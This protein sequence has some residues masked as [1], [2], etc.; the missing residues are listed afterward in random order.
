MWE[1]KTD[2]ISEWNNNNKNF[3]RGRT[4]S[5]IAVNSIPTKLKKKKE[6]TCSRYVRVRTAEA[7]DKFKSDLLK[8]EWRGV[9][10]EDVNAA[11]ES[12]LQI[13]ISLQ[14]KHCPTVLCKY[15]GT[16]YQK[17][18]ITKGLQNACK[19]KNNLY[20]DFIKCRTK[21]VEKQYKAYQNKL[22][23]ITRQAKREYY[24]NM[25]KEKKNYI[26]GTS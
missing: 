26:K 16:Y 13:Y 19:K 10:V 9:Y 23:V 1:E 25:L 15:K 11:Y 21:A 20:K 14:D 8:E 22:T 7:K 12:F 3:V 4:Y 18:W 5:G 24:N 2:K 17:P 6:E